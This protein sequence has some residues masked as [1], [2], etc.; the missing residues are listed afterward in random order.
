MTATITAADLASR[1]YSLTVSGVASSILQD[2]GISAF[3][4]GCVPRLLHKMPAN[5]I[6][7]VTYEMFRNFLG[8]TK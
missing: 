3:M 6:F 2:E 7:F 5:M 1:P 8:V 4:K